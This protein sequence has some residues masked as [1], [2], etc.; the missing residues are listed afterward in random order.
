MLKGVGLTGGLR[1]YYLALLQKEENEAEYL[2][3][4]IQAQARFD[5]PEEI[6]KN[7]ARLRYLLGMEGGSSAKKD[8]WM[9]NPGQVDK[10]MKLL[11]D[12]KVS[13]GKVE[14]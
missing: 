14:K 11:K 4:F 3:I 7:L 12:M 10:Y 1:D 2:K 13:V 6:N 5:K 8:E 9:S